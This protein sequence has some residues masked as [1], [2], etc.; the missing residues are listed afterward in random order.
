MKALMGKDWELRKINCED[1]TVNNM[2]RRMESVYWRM[3]TEDGM[4]MG[5]GSYDVF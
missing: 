2:D 5:K 1:R 3:Y 4:R